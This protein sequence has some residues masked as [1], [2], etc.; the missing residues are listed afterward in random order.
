MLS[1]KDIENHVKYIARMGLTVVKLPEDIT[2][3]FDSDLFLREQREYINPDPDADKYIPGGF[4]AYGNGSSYHHPQIRQVREKVYE[5]LLPIFQAVHGLSDSYIELMADRFARRNKLVPVTAESWHRD[6]TINYKE[7]N[8]NGITNVIY[9]G[10]TNLDK[11]QTQYFSF[12]P[13]SHKGVDL[14]S[15]FSKIS[16]EEAKMCEKKKKIVIVPPY[17]C[18]IFNELLRHEVLKRKQAINA[19]QFSCRL[20]HKYRISNTG[21]SLLGEDYIKEIIHNQSPFN[22]HE[23]GLP[24]MYAKMHIFC[25]RKQLVEFSENIRPAFKCRTKRGDY[26]MNRYFGGLRQANLE[27]FPNYTENEV[28][29]LLPRKL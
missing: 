9:G 2:D 5:H 21:T 17:H 25:W 26:I 16:E 10:W 8:I 1:P 24:P 7:T 29:I 20:Y 12:V 27:L 3:N 14:K 4:R 11:T 6:A 23:K 28:A 15:G 18:I 19:P 22:L 13:G